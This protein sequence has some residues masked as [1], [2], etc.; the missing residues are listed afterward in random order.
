MS[1]LSNPSMIQ[2]SLCRLLVMPDPPNCDRDGITNVLRSFWELESIGIIEEPS[3]PE[4]CKELC[5]KLT[6]G[7]CEVGLPWLRDKCEVPDHYDL[8]LNWLRCV[9]RRL[10]KE[11]DI[12]TKYESLIKEQLS[13]V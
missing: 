9:Q 12:L 5:V 4:L 1:S 8:C 11:P 2:L 3:N 7:R 10:I 13:L 6:Q